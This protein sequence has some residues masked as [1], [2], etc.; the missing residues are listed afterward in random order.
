MARTTRWISVAALAA[1]CVPPAP[2]WADAAA[3]SHAD[4]ESVLGRFVDGHGRV[5]YEALAKDRAALDRY[6]AAVEKESPESSPARF[7]TPDDALAYYLNA[8]NAMVFRG[9]LARGPEKETVWTPLGTG[10]S[11]FVGMEIVI[12]GRTTS[13]KSL[14]DDIVR[15][16]FQDPRIHAAL[17]CASLGCPR[18]PQ[19]A[20][21]G[22]KLQAQLDAGMRLFVSE[23]RNCA[24]DAAKKAVRLSKIFDWFAG[25][26]LAYEKSHGNPSPKILDYVNRYRAEGQKV[27]ADS[28]VSYFDYDKRINAQ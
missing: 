22:A 28:S 12:G 19:T 24:V 27:P 18:L 21:D 5:A 13:L 3:F 15:A 26:F 10:Y 7:P 14:E 4:W 20:F 16:E 23:S 1:L 17:N 11:F 2:S 25:D 8:Y 9:V 6:L